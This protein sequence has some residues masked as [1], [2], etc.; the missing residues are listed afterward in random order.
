MLDEIAKLGAGFH[1]APSSALLEVLDPEQ[2]STFEANY[3]AVP[4]D[5][6]KVLFISAANR[7]DTIPAP[8]LDRI[9]IIE[10][11]GYTIDEK[12]QIAKRYLVQRLISETPFVRSR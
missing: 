12:M 8:L 10:L 1:G 4:F 11:S 7:L 5:L 9:E 6:S 2:N 3:P